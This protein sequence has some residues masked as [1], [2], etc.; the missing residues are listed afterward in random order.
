MATVFRARDT[1]LGRAGGGQGDEP[2]GG[3]AIGI[4]RT[5]PA[6]GPGGGGGEAPGHRG[7]LR[8]RR[9]QPARAGLHRQRADRGADAAGAAGSSG[10]GGCCPRRRRW[11]PL[12][13][14]EALAVAHARGII[15]RD[16]KPENVMIDRGGKAARVVLT[17]FGVAHVT[18]LETM[19]ATGA[20]VGSPAYM[21]PEQARGHDVGPASDIWALGVM[22]YQMATGHFPF[23]GRDPLMVVAAITRGLYKKP[24]Q[25]SPYVSGASTTSAR[26]CLKLAPERALPERRGAG[27]GSAQ[28]PAGGRAGRGVGA[29]AG[30]AG[31]RRSVRRRRAGQGRRRGGDHRPGLRPQGRVRPGAGGAEPGDGLRAQT[32]G[33]GAAV[34]VDLLAAAVDEGRGGGG[35]DP[36]GGGGGGEGAAA[37]E[38]AAAAAERGAGGGGAGGGAGD[39]GDAPAAAGG[40]CAASRGARD[41][42]CE[43]PARRRRRRGNADQRPPA[44][45][46]A[47][48]RSRRR[49]SR[50]RPPASR[51]PPATAEPPAAA[52]ADAGARAGAAAGHG[53]A[54]GAAKHIA[55]QMFAGTASS[56]APAW[57]AET[58]D[59][60]LATPPA[61]ASTRS[62]AP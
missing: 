50:R 14:A 49:C 38:R 58:R 60:P 27:R 15:H 44:R 37:G 51:P 22:L 18:G 43:P 26:R 16:I 36:G 1:Q 56:V 53:A 7:D 52:A 10:A 9:R 59:S 5:L 30:A 41:R 4:G 19:T 46:S 17:D 34:R 45:R 61:R 39:G 57:T 6:R 28:V 47:S 12:P 55:V 8:L 62:G 54:A 31:A 11:S 21:S 32:R 23:N 2:G 20:L 25:V 29:A 48:A 35:G 33:G 24:S 13:L 42:R 3:R 40:A